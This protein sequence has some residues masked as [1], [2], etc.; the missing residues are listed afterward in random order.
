[1]VKLTRQEAFAE[2]GVA[3]S[4]T[5]AEVRSAYKRLA[6]EWHPDKNEAVDATE[7]FQRVNAAYHR[8]TQGGLDDDADY[9]D[10]A[11]EDIFDFFE[12]FFFRGRAP[13]PR[14]GPAKGGRGGGGGCPCGKPGCTGGAPFG[15]A[16]I[17]GMGGIFMF[18]PG[19]RGRGGAAGGFAGGGARAGA[20]GYEE[21]Y[22]DH[23]LDD[24]GDSYYD[25]DFDEDDRDFYD[26]C[27]LSP[28]RVLML[29]C[30]TTLGLQTPRLSS[31]L[32]FSCAGSSAE[33]A[34]D[35]LRMGA[36]MRLLRCL[37]TE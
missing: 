11:E 4:A 16:G 28:T 3:E 29:Y 10:F 35:P 12:A 27:S 14:R 37:S 19:G 36:R 23:D 7:K 30:T 22:Y 21:D 31:S 15:F 6:R 2:L 25:D 26:W 13:P 8:L 5:D 24:D 20:N 18:G 33:L 1:M 32:S 9:D 34:L 17:G